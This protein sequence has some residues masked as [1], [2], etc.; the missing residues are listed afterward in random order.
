MMLKHLK[1]V[2]VLI[3]TSFCISA[4]GHTTLSSRQTYL[5]HIILGDN[6][7]RLPTRFSLRWHCRTVE[8]MYAMPSMLA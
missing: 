8:C 5:S 2:P 7:M 1:A 4:C 3:H 6:F